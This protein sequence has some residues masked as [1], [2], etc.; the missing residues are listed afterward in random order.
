[1]KTAIGFAVLLAIAFLVFGDLPIALATTAI[2]FGIGWLVV[3]AIRAVL[4]ALS[5]KV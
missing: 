1:M 4:S 5:Q 2:L 3:S